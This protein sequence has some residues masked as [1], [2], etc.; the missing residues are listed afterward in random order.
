[1]SVIPKEIPEIKDTDYSIDIVLWIHSPE[2][3][4]IAE[5]SNKIKLKEAKK[6]EHVCYEL[7][8]F[9]H[10][11]VVHHSKRLYYGRCIYTKRGQLK[12]IITNKGTLYKID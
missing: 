3:F 5:Y 2:I 1:M 8:D 4:C 11:D 12:F 6:L 9:L 7:N 10:N